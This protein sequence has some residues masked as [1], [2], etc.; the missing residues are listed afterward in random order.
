MKATVNT[1]SYEFAHGK[2]PRGDGQWAFTI[3]CDTHWFC[4]TYSE[5]KRKAIKKAT[6]LKAFQIDLQS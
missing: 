5:A 2:K 3:K 1:S 4:G 6:E